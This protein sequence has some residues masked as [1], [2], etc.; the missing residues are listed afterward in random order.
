MTTTLSQNFQQN[1]EWISIRFLL[2][3]MTC[4]YDNITLHIYQVMLNVYLVVR[5]RTCKRHPISHP[6]GQAMGFGSWVLQGKMIYCKLTSS[7]HIRSVTPFHVWFVCFSPGVDLDS[8]IGFTHLNPIDLL[9]RRR[10][11][12]FILST[13]YAIKYEHS[14]VVLY[15][16]GYKFLNDL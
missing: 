13:V 12:L 8:K 6:Y 14:C 11:L 3:F 10:W 5:F 15:C 2:L 4:W 9:S 1:Y 7:S 16:C